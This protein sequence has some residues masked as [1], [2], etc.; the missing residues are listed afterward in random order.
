MDLLI[1]TV[2]TTTV[3][4]MAILLLKALFKNRMP[5]K[6]HLYIWLILIIRI[7]LPVFPQSQLS[8]FNLTPS[9]NNLSLIENTGYS[10]GTEEVQMPPSQGGFIKADLVVGNY[11][12]AFTMSKSNEALVINVW[13]LGA[14]ALFCYLVAAYIVFLMRLGHIA[15]CG[16]KAVTALLE[17]CKEK[18]GIKRDVSVKFYGDISMLA[19]FLKPVIILPKG[20]NFHE[21]QLVMLHELNHL[22]H[23]D[24]FLNA[25][26]TLFLCLNWFNPVIWKCY[27]VF[28][29]DLEVL[30]DQK[31]LEITG[32]KKAY[33]SLLLKSTQNLSFTMPLTPSMSNGKTDIQRRIHFMA[34]F[35]KPNA[36]CLISI[37][38]ALALLTAGCLSSG[39]GS[40]NQDSLSFQNLNNMLGMA[41]KEAIEALKIK[42]EE[43]AGIENAGGSQEIWTLKE[44]YK[45]QGEEGTLALLFYNDIFMGFQYD[46]TKIEPA[47][48]LARE[49]RTQAGQEYGEPSTYP[50]LE[51]RLDDIKSLDEVD[52]ANGPRFFEEWTIETDAA[53][54]DALVEGREMDRFA[55]ALEWTCFPNNFSRVVF[56]YAPVPKSLN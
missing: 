17:A 41:K 38:L 9:V 44:A 19:G 48:E 4:A 56:R 26:S 12:K 27:F 32:S 42:A 52:S 36:L 8:L 28:K 13:L 10:E 20:Y 31:T 54:V 29:G 45:I 46:F 15:P 53:I 1:N 47:Y 2:I 34:N 25:A 39:A 43:D 30:C 35:K 49:I 23:K 16:D 21:L 22:K 11:T 18:V 40:E 6:L 14:A 51:N 37:I 33:A 3:T 55:V 5:P 24:L 50:L 7:L